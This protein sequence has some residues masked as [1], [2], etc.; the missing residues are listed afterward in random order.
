MT[1]KCFL[2]Q[3]KHPDLEFWEQ[4]WH[5]AGWIDEDCDLLLYAGIVDHRNAV[6]KYYCHNCYVRIGSPPLQLCPEP[7]RRPREIAN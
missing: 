7:F 6:W 4:H 1:W 5:F 2:C 3:K